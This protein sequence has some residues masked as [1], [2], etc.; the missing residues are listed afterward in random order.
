MR[1]LIALGITWDDIMGPSGTSQ[2]TVQGMSPAQAMR[3]RAWAVQQHEHLQH[4]ERWQVASAHY[5][6]RGGGRRLF[7]AFNAC[8]KALLQ[9]NVLHMLHSLQ[10]TTAGTKRLTCALTLGSQDRAA[11]GLQQAAVSAA[12]PPDAGR[13]AAV[14]QSMAQT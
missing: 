6:E 7:A 4:P 13:V 12:L 10:A 2:L 5:L 8:S 14:A 1:D 9:R 11:E 3:L